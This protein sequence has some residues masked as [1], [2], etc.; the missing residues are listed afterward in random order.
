[1]TTCPRED[2][3]LD[4]IAID[5]WPRQADAALRAHAAQCAVCADLVTVASAIAIDRD[6]APAP[7]PPDASA[8]WRQAQYRA[9]Q[10]AAARAMRPLLIAQVAAA[11]AAV[12]L[13]A[14]WWA[15]GSAGFTTWWAGVEQTASATIVQ[16]P[17]TAMYWGLAALVASAAIAPVALYVAR[18][19][20]RPVGA[21]P[22]RRSH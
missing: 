20:D 19:V 18:L 1:M 5:Q 4:L 12:A 14:A 10:D 7:T 13:P 6:G 9:R 8:V 17:S 21:P 15:V 2:D 3:I 16:G 22:E 11:V